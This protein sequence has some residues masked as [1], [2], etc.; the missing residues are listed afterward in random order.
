M[1]FISLLLFMDTY[2]TQRL[3]LHDFGVGKMTFKLVRRNYTPNFHQFMNRFDLGTLTK[4][5]TNI[6]GVRKWEVLSDMCMSMMNSVHPLILVLEYQT[7]KWGGSLHIYSNLHDSSPYACNNTTYKVNPLINSLTNFTWRLHTQLVQSHPINCPTL[8][9]TQAHMFA[10]LR[11]GCWGSNCLFTTP[12]SHAHPFHTH[13][14]GGLE[15]W[16]LVL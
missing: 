2:D 12:I 6:L 9:A 1:T 5:H 3:D 8:P 4:L 16:V 7:F 13:P 15:S 10:F 11:P 14:E